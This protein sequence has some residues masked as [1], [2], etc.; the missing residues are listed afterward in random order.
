MLSYIVE[1][2]DKH[3][4]SNPNQHL[5]LIGGVIASVLTSSAVDRGFVSRFC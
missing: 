5:I 3:H 4:N 1:S 2:D